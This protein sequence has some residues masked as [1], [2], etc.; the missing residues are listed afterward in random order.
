MSLLDFLFPKRCVQC[1]KFGS[2]ICA[3]CLAFIQFTDSMDCLLCNRPAIDG[4]THP[5]CITKYAIDGTFPSIVYKGVV[6]KLVYA[7]KYPPYLTSLEPHLS[8][9]LYEGL[10]QKEAF[11]NVISKKSILVPIPLHAK[12][13]RKRGYNQSMLLALSLGKRLEIPVMNCLLRT[14]ETKTQ[15]GFSKEERLK[16][17]K[18]AFSLNPKCITEIGK[19]EQVFLVDDVVTSGATLKEAASVLKKAGVKSVYGITLA[20]GE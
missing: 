17:I 15:V 19:Y 3:N 5:R 12:K 18:G 13:I 11:Y 2:Y 1:K 9:L 6:K 16:N 4:L 8:D 7:F 20:H 14:K 10:V